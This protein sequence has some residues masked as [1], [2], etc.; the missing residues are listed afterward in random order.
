MRTGNYDFEHVG[1]ETCVQFS[2][3]FGIQIQSIELEYANVYLN[4]RVVEKLA[5][6]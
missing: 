3:C 4:A 1:S 2:Y 6:I 5:N